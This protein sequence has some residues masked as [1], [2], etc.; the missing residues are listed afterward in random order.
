MPDNEFTKWFYDHEAE[1][2]VM[3][4]EDIA[5]IAFFAGMKAA[6]QSV[7]PT[8]LESPQ[9]YESWLRS[10]FARMG[11]EFKPQSG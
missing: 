4:C 11:F 6:Q 2:L 10:E 3:E 5:R 8:L 9:T 1:L 7:H